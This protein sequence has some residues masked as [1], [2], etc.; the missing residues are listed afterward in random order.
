MEPTEG[1]PPMASELPAEIAELSDLCD[2]AIGKTAM[3]TA[4]AY[5]AHDELAAATE[6]ALAAN[7]SLEEA[8]Q[9]EAQANRDYVAAL[10]RHGYVQTADG[11]KRHPAPE[12]TAR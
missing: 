8:E 10:R 11:P 9:A 4:A 2:T 6:K 3:A 1:T 7:Q 12:A 5:A